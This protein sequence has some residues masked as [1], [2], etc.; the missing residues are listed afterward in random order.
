VVRD[1]LVAL[2]ARF[3]ELPNDLAYDLG[4]VKVHPGRQQIP[5]INLPTQFEP[6]LRQTVVFARC[7][8]VARQLLGDSAHCTYDHTILKPPHN[9]LETVWHQDLATA[10]QLADQRA[11]HMWVALQDVDEANGCM[12]FIPRDGHRSLRSHRR[13]T[14]TAHALMADDVS[15]SNA[16]ACPLRAGMATV[17]DLYT[18][19]STGPNT[20]AEPRLAWILHFHDR[21][22]PHAIARAKHSLRKLI[23]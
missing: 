17:H 18:L 23:R 8:D 22:R 1:L 13:R 19:H 12:R 20:T 15:A 3:D 21:P 2:F 9:V 6:R 7:L 4:E 11:V 16:V 5:E 14:E 10:P